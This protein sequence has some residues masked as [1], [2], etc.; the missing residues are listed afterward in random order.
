M[1][2]QFENTYFF[3]LLA[4]IPVFIFLFY[5]LLRWKRKTIQ[6]IGDVRLVKELIKGFSPRLF[7]MKFTMLSLAFAA[8]VVAVTNFRKPGDADSITR[9][10]IDVVIALDVSKSMYAVDLQPSRL[11]RAKQMILKLMDEMPDDRIGLVLFAGRA[12]LQMPLTTDHGA[13]RLFVTSASPDAIAMQGTVIADALQMSANAFNAKERRYKSVILISDGED[14]DANALIKSGELADQGVMINTVGVGSSEGSQIIDPATGESKK[15][16]MGNT[17]I[18]KLNEDELKQIAQKTNGVY[19]HLQ[20]TDETVS[21]LMKQLS[22]IDRKAY[23]DVSL[24]NFKTYYSW[25]A[26][27]MFVLLL[28]ENFIPERKKKIA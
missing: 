20:G 27:F 24:T 18:T 2:Y 19:V 13:A 16:A 26:G 28:A 10:G 6:R 14:H 11:E 15:D 17:V 8:G 9:K 5:L 7:T 3:W 21:A 25:F 22:Q 4:A 1:S 12:Y 23:G